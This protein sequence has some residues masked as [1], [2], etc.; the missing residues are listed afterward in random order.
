[1]AN[2]LWC[3]P[4]TVRDDARQTRRERFEDGEAEALEVAEEDEHVGGPQIL[5]NVV[6]RAGDLCPSPS[7][8]SMYSRAS[9][10]QRSCESAPSRRAAETGPAA[11]AEVL[12]GAQQVQHA[13]GATDSTGVDEDYLV[14]RQARGGCVMCVWRPS[15]TGANRSVSMPL[16]THLIFLGGAPSRSSCVLN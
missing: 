11:C 4:P 3:A 5:R 2:D 9:V 8:V 1:M 14:H 16:G 10:S 7:C 6:D 13:L 15:L 12:P